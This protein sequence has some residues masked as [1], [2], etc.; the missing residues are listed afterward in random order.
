MRFSTIST[1]KEASLDEESNYAR[2]WIDMVRDTSIVLYEGFFTR[3]LDS[4]KAVDMVRDITNSEIKGTLF[5]MSEEK[6]PGSNGFTTAFFKKAWNVVGNDV[7]CA[8]REF[9][10]NEW[11]SG[12][13]N[14]LHLPPIRFEGMEIFMA[15]LKDFQYH[16][17]CEQKRIVNL[18][19]ADDLFLFAIGHS[20]SAHVIMQA[21]E[22]FKNM[23]GLVP[24]FLPVRYLGVPLI[25]SR[26][27]YQD[28]KVLVQKLES[29]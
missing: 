23:S 9:F 11:W 8:I 4:Q 6:Y 28:C 14:V 25:S 7:T 16:H 2:N 19:F 29:R 10:S 13:W 3:V 18:C 15:G 5:S 26:L 1:F 20:N 22:E 12:L 17:K 21:L 27:L 24:S